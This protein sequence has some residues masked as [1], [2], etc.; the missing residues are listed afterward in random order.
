MHGLFRVL[1]LLSVA[2]LRLAELFIV[3]MLA[4][5]SVLVVLR[6]GLSYSMPWAEEA[7]RYLLVWSTLLAAA[8][9]LDRD[10]HICMDFLVERLPAGIT[11][12]LAIVV[13]LLIIGFL[14][15]L[16]HQSVLT[17]QN[18]AITRSPALGVSMAWPYLALP[19]AAV[20]MI[21]FAS[22]KLLTLV[23]GRRP[24]DAPGRS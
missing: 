23:L 19:V 24:D 15:L 4:I 22:R 10:D 17:M 8:R 12:P 20:L 2:C 14:V 11:R 1:D 13:H 18:I 21:L 5:M 3:I 6:Y 7:T 9:L 16:L